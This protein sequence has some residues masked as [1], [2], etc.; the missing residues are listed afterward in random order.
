MRVLILPE[1]Y[2]GD[3]EP[4]SGVFVRDQA[5]AVAR[6]HEVTVLA[7]DSARRVLAKRRVVETMEDGVRTV[8]IRTRFAR[9]TTLGRAEFGVAAAGF[10]R[11]LRRQNQTPDVIHAHVFAAGFLAILL[12]RGRYA[13]VLSEHHSDFLE[14]RVNGRFALAARATLRRADIVCPVSAPLM[15]SLQRLEP[16]ARYEVVPNV[17][18]LQPFLELN[19]HPRTRSGPKRLLVVAMLN[20]QKG[21][22]HLL[23]ALLGVARTRGDFTVDIIGDGPARPELE[24]Q[25]RRML[26]PGLVTFHGARPRPEVAAFMAQ[27]HAFVLPSVVETFAIA[28]IEAIAAG[29]PVVTTTAVPN[30][31]AIGGRFG[32]VVEPGEA[33]AL[34]GALDEVLERE[35]IPSRAA[36]SEYVQRFSEPAMAARWDA[37]Y[38]DVRTARVHGR[39]W[40]RR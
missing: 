5:R 2:P 11:R 30:H 32:V 16:A 1:W 20:R 19:G 21:I 31:E 9:G 35:W 28:P 12:S 27:S 33:S 10:V 17:I 38:Q 26:P 40:R 37:V 36:A 4:A 6:L 25:A 39:I 23:S 24:A 13:V 18:D 29:L 3:S 7:H 15:R 14:G 22:E 34:A 8:R